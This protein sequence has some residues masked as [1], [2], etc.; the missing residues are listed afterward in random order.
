MTISS[1]FNEYFTGEKVTVRQLLLLIERNGGPQGLDLSGKDFSG[2][3]L[4]PKNLNKIRHSRKMKR[5]P[6]WQNKKGGINLEG[7]NLSWTL[8]NDADLGDGYLHNADLRGAKWERVDL[9][10]ADLSGAVLWDVSLNYA[11]LDGANLQGANL[12]G[13]VFDGSS[14]TKDCIGDNII[15]ESKKY[16]LPRGMEMLAERNRFWQAS[17]IYRHLKSTFDNNG[18]Y[19]NASWAY[20]R[21]RR[22]EKQLAKYHVAEAWKTRRWTPFIKNL[23]KVISDTFVEILSDYG[24]SPWRVL[25]SINLLWV[26]FAV[27]YGLLSG[28]TD[29]ATSMI[30]HKPI[31]LLAFSLGTMTTIEA[32]GLTAKNT[33]AMRFLMPIETLCGI[34]LTGL[35]GYVFGNRINRI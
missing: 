11:V 25:L 24:E 13:V 1:Q 30:T 10:D 26:G 16:T 12:F 4:E 21:A 33:L 22:A 3:K 5:H 17:R 27:I 29:L 31:D 23:M 35:F 14:L 34:A 6:V 9:I 8:F 18:L 28:V 19:D 15:Q 32:V 7:A 20:R 2:I